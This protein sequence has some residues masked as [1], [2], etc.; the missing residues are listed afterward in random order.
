MNNLFTKILTSI[1]FGFIILFGFIS[2]MPNLMMCDDGT[3]RGSYASY[4]GLTASILFIISGI[5]GLLNY[6]LIGIILLYIGSFLQ[7]MALFILNIIFDRR[8]KK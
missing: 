5:T 2:L 4:L 1:G 8:K 7:I 3:K 6:N